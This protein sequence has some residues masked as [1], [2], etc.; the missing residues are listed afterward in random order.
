[1]SLS[2]LDF[3]PSGK[4]V[5]VAAAEDMSALRFDEEP[6]PATVATSEFMP[7]GDVAHGFRLFTGIGFAGTI[8]GVGTVIGTT[9]PEHITLHPG[10]N[11]IAFDASFNRGGDWIRFPG[12]AFEFTAVR[13]GSQVRIV[14][15]GSEVTIPAGS[16]AS[17]LDF[18]DGVR[19]LFYS[20]AQ[21]AI[22]IG[23]QAITETPLAI[24][25]EPDPTDF[26]PLFDPDVGARLFLPFAGETTIAGKY[27]VFGSAENSIVTV[28][29][30]TAGFD[31]SFNRG[32]DTVAFELLAS[33][34]EARVQGSSVLLQSGDM[35]ATIPVGTAGMTL[36]FSDGEAIL[37]YDT[38][39]QAVMIGDQIITDEL[40]Q[41]ALSFALSGGEIA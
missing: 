20:D 39:E 33:Q 30:G 17:Y 34:I 28:L 11:L 40:A 41:L 21:Q 26:M 5:A 9:A 3:E 8:G 12:Q 6:S 18:D 14:G 23:T 16:G 32:G 19:Y 35:T 38:Q 31:P 25:A 1:M 27:D 7:L 4:Q 2:Q 22:M 29:S 15:N 24:L 37:F 10:S 13:E 36:R